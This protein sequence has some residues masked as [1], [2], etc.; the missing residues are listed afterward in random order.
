MKKVGTVRKL[1]DLGRIVLPVEMRRQLRITERTPLE[2]FVDDNCVIIKKH[3]ARRCMVCNGKE[4]TVPVGNQRICRD[5]LEKAL[6]LTDGEREDQ[7]TAVCKPENR[8]EEIR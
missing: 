8:P 5:C 1:D 2:M 7:E 4:G 3:N 6:A